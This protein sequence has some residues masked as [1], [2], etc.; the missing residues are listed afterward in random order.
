MP[1]PNALTAP[2][3]LSQ[4][5]PDNK[6]YVSIPNTVRA[7]HVIHNPNAKGAACEVE[8]RGLILP[9]Y[10]KFGI[11]TAPYRRHS[12]PSHKSLRRNWK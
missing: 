8:Q 12:Q 10:N 6:I 4:L 1:P 9:T 11:P 7:I 5:A 3:F 2:F